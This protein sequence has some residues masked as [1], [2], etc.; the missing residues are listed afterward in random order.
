MTE[1]EL[2]LRL[3]AAPRALLDSR[4]VTGYIS[5]KSEGLLY[6]LA[7]TQRSH[8]REALA[9]LLWGE[10]SHG[11]ARANLRKVLANLRAL[12]GD[13]LHTDWHTAGFIHD[14]RYRV[15]VHELSAHLDEIETNPP[16]SPAH[17]E[18]LQRAVAL[19][20]GDFLEGFHVKRASAYERWMLSERERL[21]DLGV[22]ALQL[23]AAHFELT[24]EWSAA[25]STTRKLLSLE[26]W[27]EEAHLSLMLNLARS[28]QRNTA[29]AHFE[30]CKRVLA[31][32]LDILPSAETVEA[33]RQI[34]AGAWDEQPTVHSTAKGSSA[35]TTRLSAAP[36]LPEQTTP[37]VGRATEMRTLQEYLSDP[38]CREVT[39]LGAGG[40]GKTRL[41][42]A[43]AESVTDSFCDGVFFVPCATVACKDE[44]VSAVA[45]AMG[46]RFQNGGGSAQEQLANYLHRLETL[47]ILDN[48]EHLV[49]DSQILSELLQA[50]PGVTMLVTSR[51][52]LKIGAET[53]FPL[54]GMC[55]P[56]GKYDGNNGYDAID[57]FVDHARRVQRDLL[58]DDNARKAIAQI[59]RLVDGLPLA[60]ILAAG[61]SSLLRPSE[62]VREIERGS[63]I[64]ESNL[65]D[66][67]HRQR[68]MRAIFEQT[69]QRLSQPERDLYMRLSLFRGG[70]TEEAARQ[71]AA[72]TLPTLRDLADRALVWRN[73][74]GRY[75]LHELLRQYAS[76]KLNDTLQDRVLH[77]R[78]SDYY[79][80]LLTQ[81]ESDLLGSGQR[82]VRDT[83]MVEDDNIRSAWAWALD[84][85]PIERLPAAMHALGLFYEYL[86][87]A[88]DGDAVCSMTTRKLVGDRSVSRTNAR[89]LIWHGRFSHSLF[90]GIHAG[91]RCHQAL[92]IIDQLESAGQ[93]MRFERAFALLML[94]R[95][96][97]AYDGDYADSCV[98]QS[99]S[100]S[101]SL[102]DKWLLARALS[103]MA[104]HTQIEGHYRTAE[105]LA[106]ESLSIGRA[107]RDQLN[108]SDTLVVLCWASMKLN[109][110]DAAFGY[111]QEMRGL[112][113]SSHNQEEISYSFFNEGAVEEQCGHF[114]RAAAAYAESARIA[115]RAAVRSRWNG[116]RIKL[117]HM[118]V[119]LGRYEEGLE[120][121]HTALAESESTGNRT[122]R[123]QARAVTGS[124]LIGQQLEQRA[125]APLL[126]SERLFDELRH[127]IYRI[128]SDYFLG[129]VAL[130]TG[131]L[132]RARAHLLR[133]LQ[134]GVDRE[135]IQVLTLSLPLAAL[136]SAHVG[137]VETAVGYYAL[138]ETYPRIANSQWFRDVVAQPL[139]AHAAQLP[140]T[141][142]AAARSRGR[143]AD[144]HNVAHDLI[145]SLQRH[146]GRES[147]VDDIQSTAAGPRRLR[148]NG[149][150]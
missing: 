15:D 98:S 72:A 82:L 118:Y 87:R 124:A 16:L 10:S 60:I 103:A 31:E 25:I 119:Q 76:D 83:L 73:G 139:A 65:R 95:I 149:S 81:A 145:R 148:A 123:A 39:I 33:V 49:A 43:V 89:N 96:S 46:F 138:A 127:A 6:Y 101:Q 80:G 21:R 32:E 51:E 37:F 94:G 61:W 122:L 71:I 146:L 22:R 110:T 142:I 4:P 54:Q 111:V 26:P 131:A 13:C 11:R 2:E 99:L 77:Q 30:T 144:V 117:A 133:S 18:R 67:P 88:H 66:L 141:A 20:G 92:Q 113:Q 41:A 57:L 8:T 70:F 134:W 147:L 91:A 84:H 47:L 34:Q 100:L 23:L 64:L 24:Q 42:L 132:D 136:V 12:V 14:K 143:Q 129:Y 53:V 116:S 97:W 85:T 7:V 1:K 114:I 107:V 3:L 120:L 128:K 17:V 86:G 137:E 38:A 29:L 27:R 48:F 90:G 150:H 5:R 68:S 126:E 59:C 93:D 52:R 115:D 35:A 9:T 19:Y 105:R 44:I 62:I 130:A 69:W 135:D 55:Y 78:Y 106:S 28:G 125:E 75:Q 40:M 109:H 50:A 108:R 63:D 112:A 121:A 56:V 102:Q 104:R 58:E 74:G 36:T 45:N 140:P 79:I